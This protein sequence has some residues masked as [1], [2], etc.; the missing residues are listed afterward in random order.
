MPFFGIA[1]FELQDIS[2]LV[3]AQIR[4]GQSN[5]MISYIINNQKLPNAE[6]LYSS[7]LVDKF[8]PL[9]VT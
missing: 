3:E 5:P 7:Q 9:Q 6:L 2:D 8:H 4:K 1:P